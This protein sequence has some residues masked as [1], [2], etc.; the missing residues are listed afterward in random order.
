MILIL[1]LKS[2]LIIQKS[3]FQMKNNFLLNVSEK[4]NV[5]STIFKQ[6]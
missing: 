4:N 3:E 1:K 6:Q 2:N 5:K